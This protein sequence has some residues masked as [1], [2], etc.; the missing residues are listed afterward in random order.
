M[1]QTNEVEQPYKRIWGMLF[2][3]WVFAYF[4]RTI[5][6]PVVS[7]MIAND[8]AF[9][10]DASNPYALGGLLGSLFFA[11]YML[12]QFPGGYFGD[13]YGH[14]NMIILSILWAGIT[15]VFT[16][17]F[18]GLLVF[19]ALRVLTGLGEGAFYSNDRSLIAQ[20]T[21]PKK[22][23]LGM[24]IVMGGLSVGLT[25]GLVGTIYLIE[26]AVP[27]LGNN[28]WKSPFLLLGIST[29]L[30][31]I[32]MS[33]VIP[34]SADVKSKPH[35]FKNSVKGL[36]GYSL[37]FLVII[38]AVYIVTD[39][40]GLSEGLMAAIFTVFSIGFVMYIYK[41]KKEVRPV[42]KNR[43]LFLLYLSA[44]PIMWHLWFYSFWSVSIV[45]DFGGGTLT[46][47]ALVASFN[48]IA[49]LIGFPLGGYISD[50]VAH[51]ENGRRN[52]LFILTVAF[53][54]SVFI[55]AIYLMS[56]ATSLVIMSTILFISGLLFFAVQSIQHAFISDLAPAE[57]RGS[58]FGLW[59][60]I[61][62][63][64]ALLSPVISG[65]LRD[66][67]E[68]WSAPL[69]LDGGLVAVSCICIILIST[70][71]RRKVTSTEP[72]TA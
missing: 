48:A 46:T 53:A 13:K 59:N 68:S 45:K 66:R 55:F 71:A 64:G 34:K 26:W 40:L 41:T 49:G 72:V 28:A 62:E 39:H 21:P 57:H 19:I 38:M 58:A 52:T 50:R 6:G 60:L 37:V 10:A 69:L 24:G 23:G 5:T 17:L 2:V 12:T 51:Y 44:I 70:K 7:W 20:V 18:E 29:I 63:F 61:A 11:G 1:V 9:L 42:L 31:A 22:L 43:N 16:G 36:G 8:V 47:A 56:G 35:G 65:V 32:V 54:A 4:D 15:T 30:V 67:T 14:R 27:F 33:K 25:L 3:G